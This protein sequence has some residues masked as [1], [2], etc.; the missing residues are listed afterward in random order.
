MHPGDVRHDVDCA[1]ST[2]VTA[3]PG[4]ST[5]PTHGPTHRPDPFH[6]RHRKQNHRHNGKRNRNERFERPIPSIRIASRNELDPIRKPRRR[7]RETPARRR[8]ADLNPKPPSKSYAHPNLLHHLIIL[9]TIVAVIVVAARISL[10]ARFAMVL[11]TAPLAAI[12][13]IVAPTRIPNR[14]REH[15]DVAHRR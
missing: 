4:S 10:T 6:H 2:A 3:L 9:A 8:E 14:I 12:L 7:H 11:L 15:L 1:A 13:A 5:G